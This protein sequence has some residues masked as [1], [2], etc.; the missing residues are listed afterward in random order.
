MFKKH[1]NELEDEQNYHQ[2]LKHAN[3]VDDSIANPAKPQYD[4]VVNKTTVGKQDPIVRAQ[5]IQT[6]LLDEGNRTY[7]ECE[8]DSPAKIKNVGNKEML[9]AADEKKQSI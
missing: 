3:F 9:K 7:Q 6:D 5:L 4:V 2:T 8:P 1:M